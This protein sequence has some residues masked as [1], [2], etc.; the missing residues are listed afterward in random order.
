MVL[1]ED[2]G[3]ANFL[4]SLYWRTLFE[5]RIGRRILLDRTAQILHQP[6]SGVW[7]RDRIAKVAEQR[8]GAP[9]NRPVQAGDVLINGR[10][11][12]EVSPSIPTTACVGLVDQDVAFIVCDSAVAAQLT[13]ADLLQ[14]DRRR[15]ALQGLRKVPATGQVI[16]YPWDIVRNLRASLESEWSNTDA[17]ID[18]SLDPRTVLRERE[19][20]HIGE[21]T[22]IHPT[23]VVDASSG[24]IFI[25]HD[26]VIGPYAIL[27]GP[28]YIGPGS[29]INPHAWLH[30]GNAIGP[31]CKLGGEI[32][33]SVIQGYTNKQHHGFLGHSYVGSWVNLGAGTSNSDLKNTYGHVRVPILGEDIDTGATFFGAIIGDHVKTSIN[34]TIPT[35]AVL[36]FASCAATTRVLP[37]FVRSFGWVTDY[38]VI[39]GEPDRL[40]DIATKMMTRRNVDMT[41]EE[42]ELFMDLHSLARS[43]EP[44][45]RP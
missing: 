31:V 21:N 39:P 36:G 12:P 40:L 35:G 10:W 41:D 4:P 3:Y 13:S 44:S 18:S 15:K 19:R 38:G 1:F 6:I 32:D 7:V 9:A 37:K 42:V 22:H 5:S 8:C 16:R 30:G 34:A 23:A 43:L 28:L 26:V 27:E 29:R 14:V 17:C 11:L 24:T 33:G 20:I 2:E 45:I 25:S